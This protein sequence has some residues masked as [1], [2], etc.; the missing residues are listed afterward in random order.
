MKSKKKKDEKQEII[1]A[2]P[3]F[4]NQLLLMMNSGMVLQEA[5]TKVATNY[6]NKE[7]EKNI[8]EIEFTKIYENTEKT[9]GDF[10]ANFCKFGRESRVKELSRIARILADGCD[11]GIDVWTRLADE[12]EELWAER[13]RI[14]LEKIKLSESQMSFPLA[15]ML[16]AL[17]IVTAAPAMLQMY[18]N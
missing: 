9:G 16:I 7:C 15:I 13:K 14:A 5:M 3:D 1:L 11:K 8:F 6:M 2:L 10:I 18:I 4:I 12:G 17:I